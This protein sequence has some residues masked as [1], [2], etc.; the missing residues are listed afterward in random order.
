[1]V[2]ANAVWVNRSNRQSALDTFAKVAQVMKS[3]GTS[4]FIFPEGTR[5]SSKVPTL[6]PFKVRNDTECKT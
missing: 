2:L 3:K 1:M 5:F 6:L 4:L